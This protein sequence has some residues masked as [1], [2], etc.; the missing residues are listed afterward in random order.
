M[1]IGTKNGILCYDGLRASKLEFPIEDQNVLEILE[2]ID[3]SLMFMNTEG[4]Y[5]YSPEGKMDRLADCD[6][7]DRNAKRRM[8]N[9]DHGGVWILWEGRLHRY[10]L[11]RS[12]LKEVLTDVSEIQIRKGYLWVL[13]KFESWFRSYDIQGDMKLVREY[14]LDFVKPPRGPI[15]LDM[16]ARFFERTTFVV[17]QTGEIWITSPSR[18]GSVLDLDPETGDLSRLE[19]EWTQELRKI[20]QFYEL[21]DGA[22]LIMGNEGLGYLK[23]DEFSVLDPDDYPLPGLKPRI[24]PVNHNHIGIFGRHT[25]LSIVDLGDER[26]TRHQGY[27]HVGDV[28]ER[29]SYFTDMRRQLFIWDRLEKSFGSEQDDFLVDL[30]VLALFS[31]GNGVTKLCGIKGERVFVAE[32]DGSGWS[33]LAHFDLENWFPTGVCR[34]GMDGSTYLTV[35]KGG[36]EGGHGLL[37]V[38]S[39]TQEFIPMSDHGLG[40]PI[41]DL[42]VDSK[43]G[44]YLLAGGLYYFHEGEVTP[45]PEMTFFESERIDA[46]T[47]DA[48][49]NLWVCGKGLG[50]SMFDGD[51]WYHHRELSPVLNNVVYDIFC[52]PDGT[53]WALG[54]DG[55][56]VFDGRNWYPYLESRIGH[57][58]FSSP[59]FSESFD[60]RVIINFG[61]PDFR[62]LGDPNAERIVRYAL[63]K[64]EKSEFFKGRPPMLYPPGRSFSYGAI[65]IKRDQNPP[66]TSLMEVSERI[67]D[68]GVVHLSWLGFDYWKGKSGGDLVFSTRLNGGKWSAFGPRQSQVYEQLHPGRYRFEVRARDR[69]FNVDPSPA[70]VEFF[71]APPFWLSP[72]F[73]FALVVVLLVITILLY[74]LIVTKVKQKLFVQNERIDFYTNISHEIRTPLTVMMMPLRR[75][76]K[77]VDDEAIKSDVELSLNGAQKLHELIEQALNYKNVVERKKT[78]AL[79]L[80]DLRQL[81]E[82]SIDNYR[83]LAFEC[84]IELRVVENRIGGFVKTDPEKLQAIFQN[85]LSNAIKFSEP[86]SVVEIECTLESSHSKDSHRLIFSVRD[87]GIGIE[88]K[89]RS[90]IF[91]IFERGRSNNVKHKS[92]F[93]VGLALTQKYVKALNGEIRLE[94]KLHEGSTFTVEIPLIVSKPAEEKDPSFH[95]E[96]NYSAPKLGELDQIPE[97]SYLDHKILFVENNDSLREMLSSELSEFFRIVSLKSGE[98]ALEFIQE[99]HP[100]L[101]LSDIMMDEVSGYDLCAKIKGEEVTSH[102]PVVLLTALKPDDYVAEAWNVGADSY[103]TKPCVTEVVVSRII[104][105]LE[106]RRRLKELYSRAEKIVP[107]AIASNPLDEAFLQRAIDVVEEHLNDYEFDVEAFSRKMGMSRTSLYKKVKFIT[108]ESPSH[109][110][111]KHRMHRAAHFLGEEGMSVSDTAE[112]VGYL[113]LSYF[114]VTFKKEHG[115]TPSEYRRRRAEHMASKVS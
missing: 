20:S 1:W 56:S 97:K 21:P 96:K 111:R 9:D 13:S 10:D 75:L 102:I 28:D 55:I 67:P 66:D 8:L 78:K 71:V 4:L 32:N 39:E 113:D 112:K 92:G 12:E 89:D 48:E 85:L 60:G 40:S 61:I 44:F 62:I 95:C 91:R 23:G 18:L 87:Q 38:S 6:F 41:S 106:N 36:V 72:G 114:G 93:G 64:K 99:E 74:L 51:K 83:S 46:I 94:S 63:Q 22:L 49:D 77:K 105:L 80:V 57:S 29:Y 42:S 59:K 24:F 15:G 16:R 70:A 90:R 50:V 14:D 3:G 58:N 30:K 115:L 25:S 104:N 19:N 26:F 54:S 98:E 37:R 103:L 33:E 45:L 107:E 79:A 109:L 53:V 108:G 84:G 31:A 69:D 82:E 11:E 101:V 7:G 81:L 88:P 27:V 110:F 2:C 76:V 68:G 73:I 100:D 5:H 52:H 34:D 43:G 35:F 17:R 86:R 47:L 65:E